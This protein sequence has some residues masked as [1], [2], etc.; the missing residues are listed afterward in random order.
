MKTV[1]TGVVMVCM[2]II[3]NHLPQVHLLLVEVGKFP[4]PLSG[5]II[6]TS[7]LPFIKPAVIINRTVTLL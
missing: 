7:S 4:L 3:K 6:T 1:E 5:V 2:L